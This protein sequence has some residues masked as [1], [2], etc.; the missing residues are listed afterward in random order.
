MAGAD[1]SRMR[2]VL[3]AAGLALALALGPLSAR[4]DH[5]LITPGSGDLVGTP[6]T[7]VTRHE[8]TLI[9]IA[10]RY[11][12]GYEEIVNANPGVDP[13]LPGAG[14]EIELPKHRILP[15]AVRHGIVVNLAEHRLYY[16]P[17]TPAGQDQEVFSFPVSIG[18]MDWHTP[19]GTTRIVQKIRNPSW[20]PPES[21]RKEHAAKGDPL[22]AVVPGGPN[23]PLGLFAMRLGIPGGAYLIH[24]TNK[25]AGVGMQVTH[26]CMRLYPEDIEALFSMVPVDTPVTIVNEPFKVGW[27]GGRLW[28]EVHP[29]LKEDVVEP[30]TLTELTHLVV[31]A[32][33][34]RM[35][36]IDWAAVQLAFTEA[37]GIAVPVTSAAPAQPEPAVTAADNG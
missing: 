29:P 22:P 6:Q 32:T 14:V 26:G 16:F 19:L 10:R 20:H 30:P 11:G 34:Q 4:A 24:G 12:L 25:P 23:N 13:W 28:V 21:I 36:P 8:D 5:Y 15:M 2:S 35:V 9:D 1:D 33:R 7:T 31:E 37:R 3:V 17:P 27:Q 18:R